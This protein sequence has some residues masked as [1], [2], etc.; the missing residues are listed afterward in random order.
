[1]TDILNQLADQSPEIYR[2]SRNNGIKC[3][4]QTVNKGA[5]LYTN[6]AP[7]IYRLITTGKARRTTPL[8][9]L[10]I[11]LEQMLQE[12]IEVVGQSVNQLAIEHHRLLIVDEHQIL[13]SLMVLIN[14]HKRER[15][16][17]AHILDSR[18]HILDATAQDG[19]TSSK[20]PS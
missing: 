18:T 15:L 2:V 7:C 19:A 5:G 3:G 14:Q 9:Y 11:L 8:P 1:M 4:K 12:V 17:D 6:P 16:E 20:K 13:Q 10:S